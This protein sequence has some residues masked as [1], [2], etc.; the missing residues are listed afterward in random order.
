MGLRANEAYLLSLPSTIS[1]N[2]GIPL[3]P[4]EEVELARR[5]SIQHALPDVDKLVVPLASFAGLYIDEAAGGVVNVEFVGSPPDDLVTAIRRLLP[6][7]TV[8]RIRTVL[9]TRAALE[10]AHDILDA[11]LLS[12]A[13][14]MTVRDDVIENVLR[15][16]LTSS[17]AAT[18]SQFAKE[19]GSLVTFEDYRPSIAQTCYNRSDCTPWRAGLQIYGP[20][21]CTGGFMAKNTTTWF[22]ITAGHCGGPGAVYYHQGSRVGAVYTTNYYSGTAADAAALQL[23]S[24][25]KNWLYVT[26][27][28]MARTVTSRQGQNADHVGDS[29]CQS[30]EVSGFWCGTIISV[31][32]SGHDNLGAAL[33]RQREANYCSAPGDSGSPVFY[34][35]VAKG[36]HEGGPDTCDVLFGQIWEVEH[37]LA[38]GITVYTGP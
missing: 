4:S 7:D 27:G 5:V 35:H 22:W 3:A 29:V 32:W 23:S 11:R 30:G 31:N 17:E 37:G 34:G 24:S 38:A 14:P 8:L 26:G 28:E 12:E 6:T 1:P 15:V 16:G 13:I 19:F 18:K 33:V 10:R 9:N 25:Q 2:W 36:I 20:G 21:T